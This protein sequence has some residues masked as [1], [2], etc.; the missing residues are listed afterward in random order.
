M[1][2]FRQAHGGQAMLETVLAVFFI[3]LIFFALFELSRLVTA[4]ILTDHAAARAAR[5]KAVGFND[6][7]CLKSARVALIPVAGRR[8]WPAEG[9]WNEV[10]RVPIY[11]S[12]EDEGRARAVLE[13][14]WWNTTDISV[15]SGYGLGATAECDVTLRTDDYSV[16][17]RAAVESHFPL[18]MYN[19]GR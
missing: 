15:R 3:T 2:R 7:M 10:S 4:R 11:L 12:A 6:F 16:E 17:G 9:G 8:L 19:Q 14:E 18:Y 5:A 1:G 13:Y